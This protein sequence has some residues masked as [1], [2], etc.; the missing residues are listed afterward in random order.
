MGACGKRAEEGTIFPTLSQDLEVPGLTPSEDLEV[1]GLST[2]CCELSLQGK[3]KANTGL[4]EE[5][6]GQQ[7]ALEIPS[8]RHEGGSAGFLA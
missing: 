2:S 3:E 5:E 4:H 6:R 8:N 1:C 7:R